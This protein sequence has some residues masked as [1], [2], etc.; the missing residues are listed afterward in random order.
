MIANG[1]K[2][3]NTTIVKDVILSNGTYVARSEIENF[4]NKKL[5]IN[6]D[7]GEDL[8]ISETTTR[9]VLEGML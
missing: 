7:A 4:V 9:A 6:E 2:K 1:G 8:Q 3:I 5:N